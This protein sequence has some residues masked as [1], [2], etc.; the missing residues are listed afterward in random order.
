M[1]TFRPSVLP[2]RDNDILSSFTRAFES[3]RQRS[4]QDQADRQATRLFEEKLL[5]LSEAR[6]ARNLEAGIRLATTPGFQTGQPAPS[7]QARSI[8][9]I[10]RGLPQPMFQQEQD[11]LPGT[12]AGGPLPFTGTRRPED[13]RGAGALP[14]ERGPVDVGTFQG[15]PVT[16][17]DVA[18]RQIQESRIIRADEF[19]EGRPDAVRAAAVRERNRQDLANLNEAG[20]LDVDLR[21]ENAFDFF[22]DALTREGQ[23]EVAALNRDAALGRAAASPTDARTRRFNLLSRFDRKVAA[24][25]REFSSVSPAMRLVLSERG[26]PMA[27]PD[28]PSL[29]QQTIEESVDLELFTREQADEFLANIEGLVQLSTAGGGGGG[30]ADPGAGGGTVDSGVMSD[31][32]VQLFV[33]SLEGFGS[34]ED[35]I[36]FLSDPSSGAFLTPD[37][38]EQVRVALNAGGGLEQ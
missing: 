21:G 16:V 28:L 36:A 13:I 24:A 12:A 4:R 18:A 33:Q 19:A 22:E 7:Q 9:E 3:A 29:M 27:G 26:S 30:G 37:Q 2:D 32:E 10:T 23:A 11:V 6:E 31:E 8:N 5:D 38:I 1:A 17:S 15:Q 25:E 35:A 34:T 20:I 14:G